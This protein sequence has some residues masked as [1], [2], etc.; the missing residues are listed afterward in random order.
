LADDDAKRLSY[1]SSPSS[2]GFGDDVTD[3]A[4]ADADD[5]VLLRL[6]LSL[7]SLCDAALS[8]GDTSPV[9]VEYSRLTGDEITARLI[10]P[11][12]F[13]LDVDVSFCSFVVRER[14]SAI[15]FS[16]VYSQCRTK[17]K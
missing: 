14:F 2:C 3:V 7:S 12:L 9:Y 16:V 15:L 17:T 13:M 1:V 6:L 4:A 5:D 10:V 8:I 11:A